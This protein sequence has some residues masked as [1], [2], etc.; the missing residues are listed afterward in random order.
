MKR[1][2][3]HLHSL[4]RGTARDLQNSE[5]LTYFGHMTQYYAT[6]RFVSEKTPKTYSVGSAHRVIIIIDYETGITR[7]LRLY[8]RIYDSWSSW[9]CIRWGSH[10][11]ACDLNDTCW[12]TAKGPLLL[13]AWFYK[14]YSLISLESSIKMLET[15]PT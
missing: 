9:L 11:W 7:H 15:P 6:C 10:I 13:E 12:H 8:I 2:Y 1:R 14:E 4:H 3:F 5:I